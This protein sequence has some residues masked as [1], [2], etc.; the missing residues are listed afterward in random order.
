MLIVGTRSATAAG[1]LLGVL[2]VWGWMAAIAHQRNPRERQFLLL[3]SFT[4]AIAGVLLL[5]GLA[6]T[7]L[8]L[9][10]KD[11]TFSGRT[12]I[13]TESLITVRDRPVQGYGLGGV[14]SDPAS[15]VTADLHH[16]ITFEAAHSHN[17]AIELLLEGGIVGLALTVLFVVQ[18]VRLAVVCLRQPSAAAYGQWGLLIVLA[19]LFMGLAEPLFEGPHLG[20]LVIVWVTLARVR[21]EG[22]RG[23]WTA[24]PRAK[25]RARD[26]VSSDRRAAPR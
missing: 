10:D 6:P 1:G 7:L 19:L 17:S 15:P 20:L 12:D 14:W 18:T 3:V 5:L 13:W 9:Y 8:D 16:R 2:F 4:S 25:G 23:A 24:R 26:A 21:N 22:R 11:L